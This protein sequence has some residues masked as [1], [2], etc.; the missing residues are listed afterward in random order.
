MTLRVAQFS[1]KIVHLSFSM[2]PRGPR[3]LRSPFPIMAPDQN[4]IS[5]CLF[6]KG[7][8]IFGPGK[9]FFELIYLSAN[10]NHW[11]KLSDMLHETMKIKI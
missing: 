7:Q 2:G 4:R 1:L 6:L 3:A 11:P 8:I 5:K 9:Y 10:G